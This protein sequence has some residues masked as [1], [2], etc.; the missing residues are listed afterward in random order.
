MPF[1]LPLLDNKAEV[2]EEHLA[3][4]CHPSCKME[5]LFT[6]TRENHLQHLTVGSE[7]L[8]LCFFASEDGWRLDKR[9]FPFPQSPM[10]V[11]YG[12]KRQVLVVKKEKKYI[13]WTDGL[14]TG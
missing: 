2:E 1:A 14:V 4:V 6:L 13:L 9:F 7:R 3:M 5:K 8:K 11:F 12:E 10:K